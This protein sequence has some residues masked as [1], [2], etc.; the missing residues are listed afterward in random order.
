MTLTTAE[1]EEIE[2]LYARTT[3]D[4]YLPPSVQRRVEQMRSL[5]GEVKMWRESAGKETE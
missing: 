3:R 2:A 5:I 4:D 1:L